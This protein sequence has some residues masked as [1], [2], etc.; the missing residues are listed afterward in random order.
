M[1]WDLCSHDISFIHNSIKI[2][3]LILSIVSF[4]WFCILEYPD[5]VHLLV[6]GLSW[7][8]SMDQI[9]ASKDMCKAINLILSYCKSKNIRYTR[10][11]IIL[12]FN[13]LIHI[14]L[15]NFIWIFEWWLI[16]ENLCHGMSSWCW[17]TDRAEP[18]QWSCSRRQGAAASIVTGIIYIWNIV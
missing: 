7:H 13:S 2:H 6:S 10:H 9:K 17:E 18:R 8:T 15:E 14:S 11:D 1:G 3:S 5:S 16:W 4:L 12:L